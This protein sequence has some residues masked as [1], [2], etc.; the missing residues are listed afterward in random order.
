MGWS[1]LPVPVL[2]QFVA[3]MVDFYLMV[4]VGLI[5]T[6]I[7]ADRLVTSS[8]GQ[9]RVGDATVAEWQAG[10]VLAGVFAGALLLARLVIPFLTGHLQLSVINRVGYLLILLWLFAVART[11][12]FI[13]PEHALVRIVVVGGFWAALHRPILNNGVYLLLG[14]LLTF[15]AF[16]QETF[17]LL[18][19]IVRNA[20]Q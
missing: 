10:A 1:L 17:D 2:Q 13:V 11:D 4:T 18:R 3:T 7:V 8:A 16:Y 9:Y 15:L 19:G 14:G 12:L 20:R 5:I 6:A